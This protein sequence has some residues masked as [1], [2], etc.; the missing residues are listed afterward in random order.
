MQPTMQKGRQQY[1][2]MPQNY[3]S[4]EVGRRLVDEVSSS[5]LLVAEGGGPSGSTAGNIGS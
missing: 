3:Q 4:K 1:D 2:K 5:G